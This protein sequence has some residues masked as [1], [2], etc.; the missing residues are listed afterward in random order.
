MQSR[1][2]AWYVLYEVHEDGTRV[3]LA[4]SRGQK[5]PILA[6]G[7]RAHRANSDKIFVVQQRRWRSRDSGDD[8][9]IA[10]YGPHIPGRD[11]RI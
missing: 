9:F 5:Y 7:F 8:G 11:T 1:K 6:A 10:T 3:E 2:D 4:A